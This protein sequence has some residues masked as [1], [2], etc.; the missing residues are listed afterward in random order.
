MRF[1]PIEAAYAAARPRASVLAAGVACVGLAALSLAVPSVPTTD[2]W[3]W[4]VWGREV[5]DL[6][7]NTAVG[8]SPAWKPLPVLVTAPLSVF[9]DAAPALWLVIAR[10]SGLAA[11]L[12]A[13]RLAAR[14]AGRVAGVAAAI[15]LFATT[16]WLRSLSHGYTEPVLAALVLGAAE[17]HVAGSRRAALALLFLASLARPEAFVFAAAYGLHLLRTDRDARRYVLVLLTIAP[18]LWLGGEWWGA[19]DPLRGGRAAQDA[20]EL[21]GLDLLAAF[22]PRVGWPTLVVALASL[23]LMMRRDAVVLALAGW[24]AAWVG[25]LALMA[26]LGGPSAGRFLVAPEALTC[27]VAAVAIGRATAAI[28]VAS[29]RAAVATACVAA[30]VLAPILDGR[31]NYMG[32]ELR[33]AG[34]RAR[35]QGSLDELAKVTA[36]APAARCGPITL[37]ASLSWNRGALAWTL[38]RSIDEIHTV[39]PSRTSPAVVFRRRGSH[40]RVLVLEVPPRQPAG[41]LYMVHIARARVRTAGIGFDVRR[42]NHAKGWTVAEV[43]PRKA[44]LTAARRPPSVLRR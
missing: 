44:S 32:S 34:M 23:P 18:V 26:A 39:P 42:V 2:P 25:L 14:L 20:S 35:I 17:R 31:V 3:G 27:V 40:P 36:S 21:N 29:G 22:G 1:P 12:V 16:G 13:Y 7:L 10:A 6:D 37:P 30:C 11:L 28:P 38:H 9:G 19:G 15:C 4:I 41:G 5:T 33:A 24:A 43:C 8:G